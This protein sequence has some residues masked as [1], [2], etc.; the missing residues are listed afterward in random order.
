MNHLYTDQYNS[1]TISPAADETSVM[2][3]GI[4]EFELQVFCCTCIFAV[5][6]VDALQNIFEYVLVEPLGGIL[7]LYDIFRICQQ[8]QGL[9]AELRY[10]HGFIT[11]MLPPVELWGAAVVFRHIEFIIGGCFGPAQSSEVE[12]LLSVCKIIDGKCQEAA[13]L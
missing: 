3:D 13:L 9:N 11:R 6:V 7:Q 12:C 2:H 1:D 10:V 4:V 8:H 5:V